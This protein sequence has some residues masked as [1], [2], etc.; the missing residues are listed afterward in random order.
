MTRPLATVRALAARRR[1]PTSPAYAPTTA[2]EPRIAVE[3]R[4][5]V[6]PRQRGATAVAA[7]WAARLT[8]AARDGLASDAARGVKLVALAV[9]GATSA[10]HWAAATDRADA[11]RWS[12]AAPREPRRRSSGAAPLTARRPSRD[13]RRATRALDGRALA[14]PST[15]ARDRPRLSRGSFPDGAASR[16]AAA[17]SPRW[18]SPARRAEPDLVP[19]LGALALVP[20]AAQFADRATRAARRGV[21]HTDAPTTRS[22]RR[23]ADVARGGERGARSSSTVTGLSAPDSTRSCWIRHPA[24][25]SRHLDERST[26]R[27]RLRARRSDA[28]FVLVGQATGIFAALDESAPPVPAV[29]NGMSAGRRAPPRQVSCESCAGVRRTIARKARR[30][31][32]PSPSARAA[33]RVAVDIASACATRVRLRDSHPVRLCGRMASTAIEPTKRRMTAI[34]GRTRVSIGVGASR[35]APCSRRRALS[36]PRGATARAPARGELRRRRCSLPQ[37]ESR[38]PPTCVDAVAASSSFAATTQRRTGEIVLPP[39]AEFTRRAVLSCAQRSSAPA[40]LVGHRETRDRRG[41][42]SAGAR[43]VLAT[44][45]NACR[46][47]LSS[48]EPPRRRASARRAPSPPAAIAVRGVVRVAVVATPRRHG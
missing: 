8:T 3:A 1:S 20:G 46:G 35:P 32:T 11:A 34:R 25:A 30:A 42:L 39:D 43:R 21:E 4:H 12:H 29:M 2:S 26:L 17:R 18:T 22:P 9:T 40:R 48:S 24:L 10:P 44:D 15:S 16:S 6:C 23:R 47:D 31:G 45:C 7:A 14:A 5:R 13:A 36:P 41:A 33:A 19:H 37:R 27:A 28:T 38:R